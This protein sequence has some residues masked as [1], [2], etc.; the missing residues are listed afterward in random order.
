GTPGTFTTST[1][2]SATGNFSLQ[3]FT[4][5]STGHMVMS[6]SIPL[7]VVSVPANGIYGSIGGRGPDTAQIG[8]T[9]DFSTVVAN[10]SAST[11]SLQTQVTLTLTDGTIEIIKPG[12]LTSFKAGANVIT[13]ITVTTTQ[14][15]A[16]TGTYIVTVNVLDSG[17]NIL[18]T[19]THS[20]TR[21]G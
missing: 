5:D 8:Y 12:G 13:P 1:F 6:K 7:T 18:S 17:A 15:T 2:T 20:F 16:K 4:L 14:F 3:A 9:Y 19:D 21:T 11:M 10:L